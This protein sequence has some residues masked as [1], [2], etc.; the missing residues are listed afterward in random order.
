MNVFDP[1]P[2][3]RV[4]YFPG[5][6]ELD[7]TLSI[8]CED[9]FQPDE[10]SGRHIV[11]S[12]HATGADQRT[13]GAGPHFISVRISLSRIG[14]APEDIRFGMA[15][16]CCREAGPIPGTGPIR[17]IRRQRRSPRAQYRSLLRPSHPK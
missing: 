3:E 4:R 1:L 16:V 12:H 13:L 9:H 6:A 7:E 8:H 5:S 14:R 17:A 2:P 10:S 11:I 15:D